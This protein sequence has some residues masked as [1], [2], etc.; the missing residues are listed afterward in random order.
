M[1]QGLSLRHVAGSPVVSLRFIRAFAPVLGFP[2]PGERIRSRVDVSPS[3]GPYPVIAGARLC[4]VRLKPEEIMMMRKYT[5]L[6]DRAKKYS[7]RS[8]R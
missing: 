7:K 4:R 3:A 2:M 6:Q 8:G 1:P 5:E